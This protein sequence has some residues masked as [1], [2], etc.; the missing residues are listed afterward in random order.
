MPGIEAS[1]KGLREHLIKIVRATAAD[2]GAFGRPPSLS[3]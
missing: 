3:P 1:D 2:A